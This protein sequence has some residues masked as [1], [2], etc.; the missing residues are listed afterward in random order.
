VGL[1]IALGLARGADIPMAGMDYL[2]LLAQGPAK[3]LQGT[4]WVCAYARQNLVNIQ[5][6]VAP[7]GS[8]LIPAQSMTREEAVRAIRATK[9]EVYVFGSGIRR[10]QSFWSKHLEGMYILDPIWDSPLPEVM[11]LAALKSQAS[12]AY[13][14]PAYL[15][16]SDAEIQLEHIARKRGVDPRVVRDTIPDFERNPLKSSQPPDINGEV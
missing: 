9:G 4:I 7:E 5:A 1:A 2:G 8:A 15:R 14:L 11:L 6:F 16:L 13:I 3:L 12:K 10:N